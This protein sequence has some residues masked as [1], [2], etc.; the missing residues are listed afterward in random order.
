MSKVPPLKER[1]HTL[2]QLQLETLNLI[3][4]VRFQLHRQP[5]DDGLSDREFLDQIVQ[6]LED[7]IYA[8]RAM[9]KLKRKEKTE[10]E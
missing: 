8:D 3:R 10:V 9:A 5:Y 7:K 1:F 4:K 2:N 6:P